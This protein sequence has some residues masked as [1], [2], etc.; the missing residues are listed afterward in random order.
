MTIKVS[1]VLG[2]VFFSIGGYLLFG[3]ANGL[4]ALG[5]VIASVTTLM[6]GMDA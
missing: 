3:S 6:A 2:M 5:W 1:H 4:G